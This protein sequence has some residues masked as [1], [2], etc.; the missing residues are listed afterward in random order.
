MLLWMVGAM[1]EILAVAE[2]LGSNAYYFAMALAPMAYFA[3]LGLGALL[4]VLDSHR[5]RVSVT[6]FRAGLACLVLA[7]IGTA[8]SRPSPDTSFTDVATLGFERNAGVWTSDLGLARMLFVFVIVLA[9]APAVR[10]RV[11]FRAAIPVFLLLVFLA[12]RPVADARQYARYHLGSHRREGLDAEVARLR[13]EV[14]RWSTSTDRILLSPGGTYREPLLVGFQYA[15]RNGF[16]V[17]EPLSPE[18]LDALR[19][20]GAR[21]WLHVDR[22][23]T[24]NPPRVPAGRLLASGA[25]WHLWCVAKDGCPDPPAPR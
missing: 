9:L 13:V 25:W 10:R 4:R 5:E 2:R 6:I 1:L 7:P 23:E 15:L 17:S 20:R 18:R 19:E 16:A 21:L 22:V 8:F 24:S 11:P 12:W 14:N 3:S